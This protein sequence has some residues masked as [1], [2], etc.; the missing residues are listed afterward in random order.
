MKRCAGIKCRLLNKRSQSEKSTYCCVCR[1]GKI[2]LRVKRAV[3]S[4]GSGESR[5]MKGQSTED[6]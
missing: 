6:F 4:K 2:T 5:E 3:V 1:L